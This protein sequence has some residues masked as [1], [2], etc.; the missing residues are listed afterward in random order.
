[1]DQLKFVKSEIFEICLSRSHHIKFF[2]GC[3]PQISLGPFLNILPHIMI[4]ILPANWVSFFHTCACWTNKRFFYKQSLL[5]N[6]ASVLLNFFI[7]WASNVACVLLNTYNHHY[8]ET[9]CIFNIFVSI[10]RPR[11][12]Y[13]VSMWSIFHFQPH[14]YSVNHIISVKQ[15]HLFFVRFLEYL[16]LLL[17]DNLDEECE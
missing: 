8:V 2:K 16:Q 6:S 3:L 14:F 11:S 13:V 10:S 15:M 17:N 9:L 7:N 1:M 4:I 5:F 12:I